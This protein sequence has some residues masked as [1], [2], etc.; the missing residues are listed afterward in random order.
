[1]AG[2]LRSR[3]S[4]GLSVPVVQRK[5]SGLL[6]GS[7]LLDC[8]GGNERKI[9]IGDVGSGAIATAPKSCCVTVIERYM[10]DCIRVE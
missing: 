9:P 7:S 10:R 1:M 2:G 3:E 5:G 6:D 4:A 8:I